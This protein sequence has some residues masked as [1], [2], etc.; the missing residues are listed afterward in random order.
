MVTLYSWMTNFSL[1]Q[2][3]DGTYFYYLV[4]MEKDKERRFDERAMRAKQRYFVFF[5]SFFH[6]SRSHRVLS[7]RDGPREL[8]SFL[9]ARYT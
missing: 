1:V 5:L 8:E 9:L 7:Q 6:T 4:V 2:R 3:F